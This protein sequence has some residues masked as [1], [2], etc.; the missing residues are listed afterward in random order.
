MGSVSIK[1]NEEVEVLKSE[2]NATIEMKDIWE[3]P[4]VKSIIS[5]IPLISSSIDSGVA[6][7]IELRQKKKLEELF[8][9]LLEDDDITMEEVADVDCIMEIAKTI[10]VV[11]KLIRNEKV[12]YLAKLLKNSIKDSEGNVDQFEESLNKLEEL[13]LREIDLLYLLF[14]E[15][16]NI[17]KSDN[18]NEKIFNPDES[19]KA[20]VDKVKVSY[21][22]NESEV[23]SI[24]LGI[25]RTGFCIAEWKTYL[26]GKAEINVYTSPEYRKLLRKI[27]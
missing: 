16:E 1:M 24:M 26:N 3:N 8:K 10:D 17:C 25:M 15:E 18:N 12:K 11:N 20:F 19:W 6:K 7:A 9:I 2:Y 27:Q 23:I 13:S 14:L 4:V 22:L 21:E 5:F